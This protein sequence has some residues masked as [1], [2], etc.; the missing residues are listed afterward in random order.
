MKDGVWYLT[1]IGIAS[2]FKTQNGKGREGYAQKI[3]K[4]FKR[5]KVITNIYIKRVENLTKRN[6]FTTLSKERKI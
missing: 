2:I 5:I 4:K 6:I 1:I 3:K